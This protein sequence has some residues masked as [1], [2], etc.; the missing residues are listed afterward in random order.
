MFRFRFEGFDGV[1]LNYGVNL[2]RGKEPWM[3]GG[4]PVAP[5]AA[6]LTSAACG[7][8]VTFRLSFLFL[9]FPNDGNK[10]SALDSDTF[11]DRLGVVRC[12]GC[13]QTGVGG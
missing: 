8:S 10:A 2:G 9:S 7:A 12:P 3:E 4:R 11:T 1:K 13:I 6:S 5:D